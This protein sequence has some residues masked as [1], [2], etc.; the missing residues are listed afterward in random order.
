[1]S[2]DDGE[3][4][5]SKYTLRELQEALAGINRR[6]YPKN[7][8]NLRSRYEHLTGT[9]VDL[10]SPHADTS[11]PVQSERTAWDRFW[12]SR[13]IVGIGGAIC[14]RWAF[15]LFTGMD[16]CSPGKKLVDS[17]STLPARS[18]ATRSQR[19]FHLPL[20]S[21][22]WPTPYYRGGRLGPNNSFKP[23]PLRGSA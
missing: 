2:H 7:Y 6:H 11:D 17:S 21:F 22:H 13:P 20:G 12:S 23:K 19:A 15:D 14:L 3:I 16:S 4:D 5:Y 1:M 8:S 18:L 9:A 10:P